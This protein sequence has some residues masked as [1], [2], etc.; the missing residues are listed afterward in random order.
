MTKI[1]LQSLTIIN[2]ILNLGLL[3]NA[4]AYLLL[5]LH[6]EYFIQFLFVIQITKNFIFYL[7]FII[8]RFMRKQNSLASN[9]QLYSLS[10]FLSNLIYQ[11]DKM[12]HC[13]IH[14]HFA[15]EECCLEMFD[16]YVFLYFFHLIYILPNFHL[17]TLLRIFSN[18]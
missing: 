6:L 12:C 7:C 16:I 13:V 8:L 2:L 17:N 18:V 11:N 9:I 14:F 1:P 10:Y 3:R 4:I 5:V 15:N